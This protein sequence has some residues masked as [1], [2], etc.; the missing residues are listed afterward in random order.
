MIQTNFES[1]IVCSS[2]FKQPSRNR[3]RIFDPLP[4]VLE[5]GS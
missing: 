2:R 4:Y 5:F 3:S 1:E